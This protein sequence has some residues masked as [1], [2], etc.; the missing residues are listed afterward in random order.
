MV[1]YHDGTIVPGTEHMKTPEPLA[2]A[3]PQKPKQFI[4]VNGQTIPLDLYLQSMNRH[5]RRKF[6]AEMK[7]EQEKQAKKIRAIRADNPVVEPEED[8]TPPM[9]E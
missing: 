5:G 3:T 6:L 4:Q 8:I 2:F 1:E 7:K 9:E